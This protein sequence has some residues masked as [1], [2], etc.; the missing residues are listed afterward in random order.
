MD[1]SFLK[2]C[3]IF[4]LL[5]VGQLTGYGQML[6]GKVV[7]EKG[8]AIYGVRIHSGSERAVSDPDGRFQ[9]RR[10]G[11]A[12][13]FI[14]TRYDT[15]FVSA[16]E[17]ETKSV[18]T[19]RSLIQEMDQVTIIKNRLNH[20]DIGYLPPVKGVQIATGTNAIIKTEGHQGAKS[21]GNPRELF[22]KI[23]GINI[24]ESDG[25]GI[26]MGVG[27]R[28]LS[29]NRAAN[30]N[31]RQN[32]YDI[33]ADALGYPESYYTPPLEALEAIEIIRG[34]A[35]LQY[36]TQF[37]GLMNFVIRE[38]PLDS[39]FELTSRWTGGSFGYLGAFNRVAGKHRRWS[40]QLY[41]QYKKGDGYRPKSAFFQ[42]QFFG[43]LAY[44]LNDAHRLKLEYTGMNYD[45]R[46]PGGL[47]DFQFEQDL[48]QTNR[49]RNWFRVRWNVLALHYDW[50]VS[51]KA[52]F[53]VRAFGMHSER[54]ALGFLG[55]IN[56]L[57]PGG[58]R[59]MIAGLFRNA[60][61]EARYLKRYQIRFFGKKIKSAF[62]VGSRY[63]QGI[64]NSEQGTAPDGDGSDFR[65]LNPRDLEASSYRFPSRNA[66]A[67]TDNLFYLGKNWTANLGARLEYI[68]SAS[69]GYY[70]QYSIHPLNMD[71]LGIYTING[72]SGLKRVVP[73]IGA[74][75]TRR[76]GKLTSMYTNVTTNYRAVN[77][78][79][80]RINNPNIV[81]DTMMRDEYGATSEL[82][83][84]GMIGRNL[85]VDLAAFYLFYGDKI[86]I[87][88][89][90]DG[91][92]K[93]RTNIGDAVN[94][95]IEVFSEWDFLRSIRDSSEQS[96][97]IFVNFSWIDATYIRS[98]ERNYVGKKVEY[99]SE[100]VFRTGLKYKGKKWSVQLQYSYNSGQFADASNSFEASGDAV[101]GYVPSYQVLDLSG[102]WDLPKGFR[103][104]G[105]VNNLLNEQYFTRRATAYP[106]PGILPSDGRSF[107]LTLQYQFKK[108]AR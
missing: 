56:Q 12:F 8:E 25:A 78:N 55:K 62:L 19:M 94:K 30:F 93:I 29:P 32:G 49:S 64:T 84:R 14:H 18:F 5:F 86:G 40:Y 27:G 103:I 58:N 96:A 35:S 11:K 47:T 60:G 43:Q 4:G 82:G 20:F 36:G 1:R 81:V 26:Q 53:N 38:A 91:V 51:S 73:L 85:Y 31:M 89:E 45:A 9:I 52:H 2:Y 63:Y 23:P 87:A 88:P 41:H 104:E 75:A 71:T 74:G 54:Y 65:F 16:T 7:D 46:Q 10:T 83:F 95:G 70:K 15:L 50:F 57:D 67:F 66:A 90:E 108:R 97:T 106:G 13:Q 37:G 100:Y 77:F 99:V 6:K 33:S 98:R 34:S 76:I 101:L 24:W 48:F 28:G 21:T 79:D 68:Q 92:R 44:Y 3:L 61:V 42:H 107:Y 80:I 102:R 17:I 22:A 72:Q 59:E 39:P 105:G 69:E